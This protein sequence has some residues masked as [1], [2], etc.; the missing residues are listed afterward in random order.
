LKGARWPSRGIFKRALVSDQRGGFWV[1][2]R[3]RVRIRVAVGLGL[4]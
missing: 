4:N 1:R 2:V 3:V